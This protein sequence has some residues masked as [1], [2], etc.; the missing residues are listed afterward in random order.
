MSSGHV[1]IHPFALV[2]SSQIGAGTRVWAFAHIMK[3]AVIGENCNICDHVFIETGAHV[4]NRVT[5]KNNVLI[6]QGVVIG[7]D[8]FLGPNVVFTN[9]PDPRAPFKK[10]PSQ[11]IGT[12]V[13]RGASIGANS[14]ILCGIR[15]GE[16]A[17]IGAGSTVTKSVPAYAL[18]YGNPA[19]RVGWVCECA[20]RL[21]DDLACPRCDRRYELGSSGLVSIGR[22]R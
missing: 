7:D 10:R 3:G 17:F 2:E 5:I 9:D 16:W 20:A 13:G 22:L 15:I 14:T 21:S 18:V 4:G 11:L 8:V 1:R 19:R 12:E 6:W